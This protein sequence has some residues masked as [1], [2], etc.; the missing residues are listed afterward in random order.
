MSVFAFKEN[1]CRKCTFRAGIPATWRLFRITIHLSLVNDP[2][3][4][5]PVMILRFGPE[6]LCPT[7]YYHAVLLDFHC[8]HCGKWFVYNYWVGRHV[9]MAHCAK[10]GL[11]PGH[12][13]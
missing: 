1:F 11:L 4:Q 6:S 13:V 9:K 3:S 10:L 8:A 5:H 12:L 2:I 7:L